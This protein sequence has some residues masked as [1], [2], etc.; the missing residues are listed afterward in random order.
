[1]GKYFLKEK[2]QRQTKVLKIK[3]REVQSKLSMKYQLTPARRA[4][5]L[6]VRTWRNGSTCSLVTDI[7]S[8][9]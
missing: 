7:N 9:Y 2:Y 1:M 4:N 8:N 6:L 5:M 3:N